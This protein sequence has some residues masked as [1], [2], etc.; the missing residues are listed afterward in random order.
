MTDL[1]AEERVKS[2]FVL[3]KQW[4]DRQGQMILVYWLATDEGPIRL[5]FNQ[6]KAVLFVRE[7][8]LSQILS[9]MNRK[10]VYSHRIVSLKTFSQSAVVAC[11]CDS[12]QDLLTLR[13]HCKS[14]GIRLYEEDI[15]PADRFLME[16]FIT[17][18]LCFKPQAGLDVET[19]HVNPPL[20]QSPEQTHCVYQVLNPSVKPCEH[21]PK[22]KFIS[23]DIETAMPQTGKPTALYS[24]GLV[25]AT[26]A[27]VMLVGEER[28]SDDY[29]S[30]HQRHYFKDEKSLLTAFMLWVYEEDPDLI[31]G[32]NV[33]DFDFRFL[34]RKCE[35]WNIPFILGRGGE[36]CHWR[37]H[38]S[39]NK[40]FLTIP[41]RVV[42][43]GIDTLKQAMYHFESFSLEFVSQEVLKKGKNIDHA[44]DRGEDHRGEEITRLYLEDQDAFIRYNLEDCRLVYEIFET[45]QLLEFSIERSR[46]TGHALDRMGGSV[47]AFEYQYLPLL[48]R[49]GYVAPNHGDGLAR[50]DVPGGFVMDSKPGLFQ[51]V[52]VLDFKSLYPSI[53]R[54]FLIDPMGLIEG[55]KAAPNSDLTVP[56]FHQGYFSRTQHLLPKII[57]QLWHARDQAKA[58]KNT[59]LS[60]AI[61]ILMNSFYGVLGSTVCRFYDARL[62]SSITMRGHEILQKTR[63]YIESQ[64]YDV[65]YGDTD[66]VFVHVASAVELGQN[67]VEKVAV[68]KIGKSLASQLNQWWQQDIQKNYGL[69]S[70]L[71]LEFET[72]YQ[73][74]LMPTIRGSEKG[75]K[76][77]Y[78]GMIG[79]G[80]QLQLV[81][82]GLESVR[83]DWTALAKHF[84]Q[85][86]YRQVFL[87]EPF[88]DYIRE[89]VALVWQKK[90]DGQLVYRK[91]LRQPVEQ[92]QKNRPPHVKAALKLNQWLESQNKPK[93]FQRRGGWIEYVMTLN[94]PEP[95][96]SHFPLSTELDYQHYIEKQVQPIADSILHFKGLR[97]EDIVTPQMPLI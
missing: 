39:G 81:F 77:R 14:L 42:L 74:F 86:L 75:S 72:H 84:Q 21:H 94:G 83:T 9:W 31:V 27:C 23:L 45:L 6:Q 38:P 2:G 37:E 12:Y 90:M 22:L 51:H 5:E 18:S 33:V 66:S 96:E 93:R 56:G 40:W 29:F 85:T 10:N 13:S 7:R 36:A 30:D 19:F 62:S 25:T 60:Q 54:T 26:Q 69:K 92:Y 57:E 65:I 34:Q 17:S 28:D 16:R 50:H 8:D 47:A 48:H 44:E 63:K 20:S 43:D 49:Q 95:V 11:Y 67:D 91:R 88:Q 89:T 58:H 55:M 46:L 64:G 87:R 80:D 52:I 82:K 59:P 32:W 53:I 15:R 24:I 70:F 41:G 78:A 73:H 76:K 71:E 3:T 97:F 4:H 35:Q 68:E 1:G 79:Q 61:K